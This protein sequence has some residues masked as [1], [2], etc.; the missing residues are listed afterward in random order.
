MYKLHYAP[1]NASIIIRFALEELGQPYET[2]LVDRAN[3]TQ[4]SLAYRAIAPTGLIPALQFGNHTLFETAAILLWLSEHHG[5]LAPA[6]NDPA[7]GDFLKWL[8]FIA[9]TLHADMRLHFYPERYDASDRAA[10]QQATRLRLSRHLTILDATVAKSPH[11]FWTDRPSILTLYL[12]SLCRWVQL[13]PKGQSDWFDLTQY[14][15][16]LALA[17]Q[18]E[19]RAPILRVALD[20]GLGPTPFS[21]AIH[22]MPRTGSTT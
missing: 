2:I 3:R 12:V 10:F 6:P 19:T 18:T 8:F 20:E 7:R 5:D 9:N 15:D 1:D 22:A 13:F 21:A 11:L 4:D 14:P 17:R 16:I